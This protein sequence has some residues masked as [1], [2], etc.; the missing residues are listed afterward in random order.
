MNLS[1][2]SANTF[3]ENTNC[4]WLPSLVVHVQRSP[5][6][7][8]TCNTT[9]YI[10]HN[11]LLHLS[12]SCPCVGMGHGTS[13]FTEQHFDVMMADVKELIKNMDEKKGT[14]HQAVGAKLSYYMRTI[15]EDYYR[16][17]REIAMR[18]RHRYATEELGA[19]YRLLCC[20]P[21]CVTRE[22]S[23]TRNVCTALFSLFYCVTLFA[24]V[25]RFIQYFA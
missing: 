12:V 1:S 2:R 10:K 21:S 20:F 3:R 22:G 15:E 25:I 7:W 18:Q 6:G 5:E 24:L 23:N 9:C 16:I 19:F 14:T 8:G 11:Y 4:R 17:G 13:H